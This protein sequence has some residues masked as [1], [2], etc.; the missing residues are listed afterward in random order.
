MFATDKAF[1]AVMARQFHYKL[2]G[3]WADLS[4]GERERERERERGMSLV[5]VVLV[6]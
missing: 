3:I 1:V 6:E 4:F 5:W 2:G